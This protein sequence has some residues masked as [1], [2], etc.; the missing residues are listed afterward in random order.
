M[1]RLIAEDDIITCR[2]L[3]RNIKDRGYD[4]VLARNGEEA[5]MAIKNGDIRKDQQKDIRKGFT[6]GVDDYIS[7]PFDTEQLRARLGTGK[8]II[9][10][11]NQLLVSKEILEKLA[12]SDPLTHLF[13]RNEILDLLQ[14]ECA[15]S[16][17]ETRPVSTIMLDVL[18]PTVDVYT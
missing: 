9:N 7:K 16:E 10:L 2:A 12:T 18:K 13:N 3:E 17:R 4:V 15:R 5:W 11:Q 1:K 14:E 6:A 8:R